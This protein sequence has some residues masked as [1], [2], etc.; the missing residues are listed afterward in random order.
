MKLIIIF[1]RIIKIQIHL[2]KL[3]SKNCVNLD[4]LS[5]NMY[6]LY[7]DC[8]YILLMRVLY[9]KEIANGGKNSENMKIIVTSK[10]SLL[11]VTSK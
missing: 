4:I 8:D 7:V 10:L 3:S 9:M 1:S 6:A 11:I 2:S 5:N